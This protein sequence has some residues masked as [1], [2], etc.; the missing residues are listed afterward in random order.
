MLGCREVGVSGSLVVMTLGCLDV[1][2]LDFGVSEIRCVS[3]LGC[4]DVGEFQC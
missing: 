1:G 2:C 3:I 4:L